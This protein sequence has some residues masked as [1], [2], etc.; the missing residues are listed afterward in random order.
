M[1]VTFTVISFGAIQYYTW[2]SLITGPRDARGRLS[3]PSVVVCNAAGGRMGR[4]HGRSAATG[5]GCVGGR[6]ADTAQLAS[7][8]TSPE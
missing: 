3:L 4:A 2:L 7:T 1:N 8:V 5:P 6:A